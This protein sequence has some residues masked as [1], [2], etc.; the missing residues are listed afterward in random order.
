MKRLVQLLILLVFPTAV[1]SQ[2]TSYDMTD[3]QNKDWLTIVN[4]ADKNLQLR[5]VKERLFENRT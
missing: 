5:L 3:E 2:D 1:F 4:N